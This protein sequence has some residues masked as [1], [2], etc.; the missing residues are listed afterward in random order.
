MQHIFNIAIEVEDERIKDTIESAAR[1]SLINKLVKDCEV[2]VFTHRQTWQS[3]EATDTN[4]DGITSY[5]VD[6]VDDFLERN[7]DEILD[8]AAN[9]LSE[10]LLRTKKGQALL[11]KDDG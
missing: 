1:E 10:K 6:I 5:M 9:R 3:R 11:G 2:A 7:K 4:R 8:K